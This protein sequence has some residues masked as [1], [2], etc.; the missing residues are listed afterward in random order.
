VDAAQAGTCVGLLHGPLG[1]DGRYADENENGA[2]HGQAPIRAPGN[3]DGMEPVFRQA[4]F[5][6]QRIFVQVTRAGGR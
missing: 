6:P 5:Y 1:V 2:S 4:T 3:W